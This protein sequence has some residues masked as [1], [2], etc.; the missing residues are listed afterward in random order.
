MEKL[1]Q[2]FGELKTLL[3]EYQPPLVPKAENDRQFD[4]W[5]RKEVIVAGRKRKEIYFAGIIIQ[6]NYVGFYYMPVYAHIE[7]KAIF[8]ARLLS[9]LKGKSCFHI[10]RLDPELIGQIKD[11]L[12]VG[13]DLYRKNGWI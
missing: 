8:P 11:A 2:I 10:K 13:H 5:S 12:K 6:K 9:L 7:L 3:K 1:N 4:L